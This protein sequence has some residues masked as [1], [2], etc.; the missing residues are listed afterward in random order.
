MRNGCLSRL[1]LSSSAQARIALNINVFVPKVQSLT[2]LTSRG[3]FFN[4][5]IY[6]SLGR[7]CHKTKSLC[8]T[9][10]VWKSD[11]K[12]MKTTFYQKLITT[13]LQG[14]LLSDACCE[15]ILTASEVELLPLLD[16][17]YQVRKTYFQR[18]VQLHI[19]NNA[20]NGYCPEDCHYCAAGELGDS[21]Y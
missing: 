8:Y 10:I 21:R 16:A 4:C 18:T 7:K 14:E 15:K 11:V 20:Q 9:E 6:R 13:S 19:L 17:A 1:C 12:N 2:R 3:A 5:K